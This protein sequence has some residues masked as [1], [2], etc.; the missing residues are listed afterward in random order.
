LFALFWLLL[1]SFHSTM[2]KKGRDKKS[3]RRNHASGKKSH[4]RSLPTRSAHLNNPHAHRSSLLCIHPGHDLVNTVDTL[5]DDA[6]AKERITGK[7]VTIKKAPVATKK[8]VPKATRKSDAHSEEV[9]DEDKLVDDGSISSHSQGQKRSPRSRDRR[10]SSG[11]GR[12]G[13]RKKEKEV[14]EVSST[15]S[16]NSSVSSRSPR[17]RR[18]SPSPRRRSP[19]PRRAKS[20]DMRT[21][22]EMRRLDADV[23]A[24]K[25][26][27]KQQKVISSYVKQVATLK[28]NLL[29][30]EDENQVLQSKYES[31]TEKL[32]YTERENAQLR[33]A[34]QEIRANP[35]QYANIVAKKG[36]GTKRGRKKGDRMDDETTKTGMISIGKEAVKTV[37]RVIKFINTKAQEET[38]VE[39]VLN[40][41][42]KEELMYFSA[43]TEERKAE[44]LE[45]RVQCVE[46]YGK[47]WVS[48]L[49]CLRT[50]VQ[51]SAKQL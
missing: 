43:D 2:S 4:Q 6:S 38:F 30:K 15:D 18:R 14:L 25:E 48:E 13:G 45:K 44:V 3:H 8:P 31:L 32:T 20:K 26:E 22:K 5:L 40:H 33:G 28:D 35:Q 16:H 46:D 23:H 41:L 37:Y 7:T 10:Q 39:M 17:P 47:D 50:Y 11:S 29:E 34:L 19:S 1:D 42:G 51:V 21:T 36:S 49:N 27:A 9:H 12:S 24:E